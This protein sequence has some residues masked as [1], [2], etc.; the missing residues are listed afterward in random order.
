MHFSKLSWRFCVL[1]IKRGGKSEGV[2]PAGQGCLCRVSVCV[3]V[4][5]GAGELVPGSVVVDESLDEFGVCPHV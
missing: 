5:S 1:G 4:L 2:F 3:C